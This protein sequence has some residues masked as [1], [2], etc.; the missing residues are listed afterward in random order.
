MLS[1]SGD[2]TRRVWVGKSSE[3]VEPKSYCSVQ[4]PDPVPESKDPNPPTRKI[5][6]YRMARDAS[7]N[8][9]TDQDGNFIF[10]PVYED[11]PVKLDKE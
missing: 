6:G 3:R 10:I 1:V 11:E 7:G 8:F 2:P 4:P 9:V 5:T